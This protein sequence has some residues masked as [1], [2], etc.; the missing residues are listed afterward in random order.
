MT[1]ATPPDVPANTV[2][3]RRAARQARPLRAGQ[4]RHAPA[5]GF[6]IWRS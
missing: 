1:A 2:T 6:A 5:R 3:T 4:R